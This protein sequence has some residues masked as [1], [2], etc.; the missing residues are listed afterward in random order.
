MYRLIIS[1]RLNTLYAQ[2]GVKAAVVA[3]IKELDYWH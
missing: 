2:D 3:K 1:N